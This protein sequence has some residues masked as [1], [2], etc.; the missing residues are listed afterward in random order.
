MQRLK[1]EMADRRLESAMGKAFRQ[2]SDFLQA[3]VSFFF[4]SGP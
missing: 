3:R 1:I 4:L 2:T